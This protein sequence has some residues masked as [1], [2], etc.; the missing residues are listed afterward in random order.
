MGTQ[1]ASQ[2][3]QYSFAPQESPV[4]SVLPKFV[5]VPLRPSLGHLNG[6]HG[7]DGRE[8]VARKVGDQLLDAT[9]GGENLK[10]DPGL[11]LGAQGWHTDGEAHRLV[12][13]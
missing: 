11:L 4:W 2:A 1:K 12:L 7:L 9:P 10:S 6:Q 3:G 13:T 8:S 5:G